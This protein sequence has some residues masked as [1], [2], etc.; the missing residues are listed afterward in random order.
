MYENSEVG[1]LW[2]PRTIHLFPVFCVFPM[3]GGQ[4]HNDFSGQVP[5]RCFFNEHRFHPRRVSLFP[6]PTPLLPHP[7]PL[8]VWTDS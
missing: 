6:T 3:T 5:A 1:V 7:L 2:R 4:Q 8:A